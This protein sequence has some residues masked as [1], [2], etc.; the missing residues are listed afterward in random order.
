MTNLRDKLDS[1]RGVRLISSL[2]FRWTS[3]TNK[4]DRRNAFAVRICTGA[5]ITK[6]DSATVELRRGSLRLGTTWSRFTRA[7]S[8]L[9]LGPQSRLIIDGDM[10]IHSGAAIY[11]SDNAELHLGSGYI[12][13][14]VRIG[15]FCSIKIGQ[16]VAIAEQVIIRDSD[17]HLIHYPGYEPAAPIVIGNHVWIGMRATILKGVTIGDGAIVAAGSLVIRD[18]PPGAIVAGVPARVVR[19]NVTWN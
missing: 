7:R 15:C 10:R 18:V 14:D 6:A 4:S 17:N 3:V 11:L 8:G 5:R 16:N 9:D 2:W 1:L 13:E 12:N 19:E